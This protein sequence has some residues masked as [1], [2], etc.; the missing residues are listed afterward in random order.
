MPSRVFSEIL[1]SRE[2]LE[3]ISAGCENLTTSKI[4]CTMSLDIKMATRQKIFRS[5]Q[6]ISLLKSILLIHQWCPGLPYGLDCASVALFRYFTLYT[7]TDD[8]NV[9]CRVNIRL[10]HV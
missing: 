5:N 4:P 10:W 1:C 2:I 6:T 7:D 8:R 9:K 3:D